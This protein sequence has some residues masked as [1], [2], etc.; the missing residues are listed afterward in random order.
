MKWLENIIRKVVREEVRHHFSLTHTGLNKIDRGIFHILEEIRDMRMSSAPV[1]R[2]MKKNIKKN[3][4]ES[5]S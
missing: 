4:H 5:F 2:K 1:P 3:D